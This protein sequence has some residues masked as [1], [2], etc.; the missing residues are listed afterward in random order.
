MRVYYVWRMKRSYGTRGYTE[1]LYKK[2]AVI[3]EVSYICTNYGT[4]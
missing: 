2:K 1:D 4:Y 3:F